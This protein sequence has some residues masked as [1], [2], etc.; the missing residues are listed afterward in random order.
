[1]LRLRD[2]QAELFDAVMPAEVRTLS[3]ELA[4]VDQLLDDDRFL[5]PFVARFSCPIGRPTIP[6]ETYLRL[7]YL[8]HRYG[9]GY[10][11]LVEEVSDSISWRRFCRIGLSERVPHSTTVLKLTRRFGPEIVEELNRETLKAAV[12]RKLLRSRRL[13]VDCTVMEADVRY[14]TDSGLCAHAISRLSR[15]VQA[16]KRAGLAVRT[17]FRNRSR[18]AAKIA[19]R[20]S[21]GMGRPGS[22]ATVLKLTGELAE[23]A[24]GA[25]RQAQ[26]VLGDARRRGKKARGKG[27]A[28]AVVRQLATDVERAA[29]VVDQTTRRVAGETS[30]PDRIISLCDIDAR[31]IRRGKL[32]N[33]NEFG[34]KVAL[35]D[36]PEG[37][38]VAH[39]VHLGNPHDTLTLAS[40][41]QQALASG[42]RITTVLADRGFGNETADQIIVAAGIAD[43]VIPRVGRADPVEATQAWRRRYRWRAGAEGRI[44]H[45]K[46]RFGWNRTRLKGHTGARIWSGYGILATNIGRMAAL[47]C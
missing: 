46:R 33:P 6:I 9:L 10:E 17:R 35:G 41:L 1:M 45:L 3:P 5:A 31:P 43:K 21:L 22:K 39:E 36:S 11:T 37:F 23:L 42:M 30:I 38:V 25:V 34:Y 44:S 14:P 13:R 20:M 18:K 40:L 7:M 24:R 12:Q 4:A 2:G 8:K 26:R 29:R 47:G 28:A 32:R 15:A 19:R 16:V 27:R